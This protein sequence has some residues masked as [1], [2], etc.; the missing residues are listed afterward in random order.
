M[1]DTTVP[2]LQDPAPKTP[3]SPK[4]VLAAAAAFLLP[5]VA[6]ILDYLLGDGSGIFA[7]WPVIA[8]I[9]VLSVLTS[10]AS[11]VAGYTKRDPLRESGAR[12]NGIA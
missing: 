12:K 6:I 5:T 11:L 8:Q 2:P 7:G 3:I 4:V 1:T 10:L 9:A